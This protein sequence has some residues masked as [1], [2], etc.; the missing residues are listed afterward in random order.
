MKE[1][2]IFNEDLLKDLAKESIM[3]STDIMDNAVAIINFYKTATQ[4]YKEKTAASIEQTQ[5]LGEQYWAH[6]YSMC[7]EACANKMSMTEFTR[8]VRLLCMSHGIKV[9]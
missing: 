6:F 2:F 1:Q 3:A 5:Q 8:T 7:R 4:H 9:K